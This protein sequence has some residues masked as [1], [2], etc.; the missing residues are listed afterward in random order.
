[1]ANINGR[2]Q[3]SS[4]RLLETHE[5][6]RGGVNGNLNEQAQALADRTELLMEEKASKQ[7]IVNGVREYGTYAAFWADR[8]NV[9]ANFTVIIGE[10]NTT[11][12][13]T[14]GIGNNR[15]DG[16][17]LAKS[18]YDPVS[19]S[20]KYT[21]IKALQISETE[22]LKATANIANISSEDL[23]YFTDSSGNIVASID[24]K[25]VVIAQ[26]L[27]TPDGSI[28][29]LVEK[30]NSLNLD[31]NRP[32]HQL[33]DNQGNVLFELSGNGIPTASF[34]FFSSA[35][36]RTS[37]LSQADKNKTGLTL[38]LMSIANDTPKDFDVTVAAHG[39]D[40]TLHQ[41][42][43]AGVKV[44]DNRLFVAFT[45]FSTTATDSADGR[46]VGRFVDFDFDTQTA[47]VSET[48]PILGDLFGNI[49]RH[50]HFI[51]LKDRILLILNGRMDELFVYETFDNC[52]TFTLKTQIASANPLPWALALDSA[53][54]IEEGLY[55]GR[56]ILSLFRYYAE[57]NTGDIGTVY[58][59]DNGATW[60]RGATY[61]GVDYF[62]TY[63]SINEISVA[64]DA[65]NNLIF[66]I[67]NEHLIAD[68]RY[69]I[70]AKSNDGGKTLKFFEQDARTPASQT[71]TGLKQVAPNSFFGIPKIIATCPSIT[72]GQRRAMRLRLSYDGCKSWA[73]E[74]SV[75]ND[76][77]TA[78]Y[79]SLLPIDA[80][81]YALIYEDGS[82]N[83]N[84]SIKIKF[85][86]LK[87]VFG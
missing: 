12:T 30:T 11:G 46:L 43:A 1:M 87:K 60:V 86:N 80:K 7:E 5:L 67:R 36:M 40:G 59:D 26:G 23:H 82:L 66:M 4:V 6:A 17:T 15:W 78:G 32:T 21:D 14:W 69:L 31:T 63:P 68:A 44:A 84:Q 27:E 50:P 75:F 76:I 18:S 13:G 74:H 73:V 57:T 34:S 62:P 19:Q 28:K 16:S 38:D 72:T 65:E 41:R 58:S 64:P 33:I 49:W 81:N 79:S 8:A 35:E 85:L 2:K 53:V 10:E 9:P 24:D 52:Q 47:T 3:W 48:Q 39:A 83:V 61:K 55:A 29:D 51:K 54:R 37:A 25:G 42:M 77:D 20:K 22:A 71:Q 70:F 45:Q 56:I